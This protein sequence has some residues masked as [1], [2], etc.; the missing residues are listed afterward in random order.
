MNLI[1]GLCV[2]H[3]MLFTKHS[4]APVSTS[5]RKSRVSEATSRCLS[6]TQ[7][8]AETFS[9]KGHERVAP[10]SRVWSALP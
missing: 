1:V 2:G 6:S 4:D 5:K 9:S 3:D 7:P 10:S 8:A